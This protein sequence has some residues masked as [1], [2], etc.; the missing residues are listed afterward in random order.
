MNKAIFLDRDGTINVEKN[1]LYRV[2]DFE[3]IPG[4]INAIRRM[5]VMSYKVIVVT[6]QS[7]IA[8]GYYTEDDLHYLHEFIN[9]KLRAQGAMIDAFYYCPHHPVDGIGKYKIT[10]NCRKPDIGLYK[11]AIKDYDINT[12]L[13]WTVGDRLRDLEPGDLLGL[14]KALVLTGYGKEEVTKADSTIRIFNDLEAFMETMMI[15]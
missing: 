12:D 3:F 6:N 11:Q 9:Q 2:E 14:K 10:C 4:A 1:Y 7:G 8:R 15:P 5:N 13:S